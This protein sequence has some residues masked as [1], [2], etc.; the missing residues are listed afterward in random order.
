ME[1]EY[2]VDQGSFL[3]WV[4]EGT[5]ILRYQLQF[6]K[7]QMERAVSVT[8]FTRS[9]QLGLTSRAK[10]D[11]DLVQLWFALG[12]LTPYCSTAHKATFGLG[13]THSGWI[14]EPPHVA[15]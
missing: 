5:V 11:A 4:D 13:Q 9:V 12:R 6:A 10:Q 1:E 15:L 14:N 7:V 3:D 2:E 8:G